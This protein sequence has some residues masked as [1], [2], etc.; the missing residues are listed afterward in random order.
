MVFMY[1]CDRMANKTVNRSDLPGT[2]SLPMLVAIAVVLIWGETFISTKV[3]ISHGLMPADIFFFR[4]ILAYACIWIISPKKIWCSSIG[5]E[6]TMLALGFFG[7][8]AYFLTENTALQ[9][10]TASN[11]GILVCSAPLLT[12]LILS[13]FYKDERMTWR[14]LTGSLVAFAGV[15]LVVL[16]GE[17]VLHLNPL[18]DALA[19]GA[20]L[21]WG[22]YSL[23]MKRVSGRY[24]VRFITRKVFAYGLITIIPYFIFVKPLDCSPE[25]LGQPQVWG[26]LIYLG[27][28]ASLGCFVLWNWC[29]KKLGTVRT[30]N[31]IYCQP[32]FTMLIAALIL[33]ERITWMAILGT[34]ILMVGMMLMVGLGHAKRKVAVVAMDSFKGSLSSS[35]AGEAVRE[36]L[37]MGGFD[38]VHCMP[39]SDGGEGFCET[40][41]HYTD[42]ERIMLVAHGPS[43]EAL[44]TGYVISDGVAYIESASVC[45]FGLK[46][47]GTCD[48]LTL[49]SLGLGEL[50]SDAAGRGVRKIVVGLGGTCTIDGGRGML[51]A[52][53]KAGYAVQESDLALPPVEAWVDTD[54]VFCGPCGAVRVFGAQKGLA[55]ESFDAADAAMEDLASEYAGCYGVDVTSM[56]GAGAAGGIAGAMAAALGASIVSGGEKVIELSGLAKLAADA[57]LVVTGEGHL[58]AQT[59]TGKLPARVAAAVKSVCPCRVVCL[60]GIADDI[61]QTIF[62]SVVSATPDSMPLAEVMNPATA[63][64]NLTA[65]AKS[66]A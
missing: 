57:T 35:E 47:K 20:A 30:T 66:L 36:G 17:L 45:G 28:V 43:G 31:L 16:N 13:I 41:A 25:I 54:A 9:Y 63:R 7:G 38:E 26:N 51:K 34:A 3:I 64:A 21:T 2:F 27:L 62:D 8:S 29:L 14:Q 53:N 4:F 10:S 49:T 12:A 32:F 37:L 24:D 22:F 48:P 52:L 55:S 60:A 40:V 6:L 1:I 42:A 44:Q 65:A 11:V 23:F 58:D 33:G 59:L 18:G 19:I 46:P 39:M 5:D 61:P 50:I 56:P 15:A